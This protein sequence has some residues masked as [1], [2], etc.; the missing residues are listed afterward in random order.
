MEWNA[1]QGCYQCIA[2]FEWTGSTCARSAEHLDALRRNAQLA[3]SPSRWRT[4]GGDFNW[5]RLG[6]NVA[7]GA[8]VGTTAGV[9]TNTAIR[10]YQLRDGYENIR[11]SFG[12]GNTATFGEAI[13]VR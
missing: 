10:N 2:D 12:T 3:G 6:L 4:E 1:A 8:V 7:A 11:C 5:L 9:L 13:I